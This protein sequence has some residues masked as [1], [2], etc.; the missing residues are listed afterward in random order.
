MN[1]PG[2]PAFDPRRFDPREGWRLARTC[3]G[4]RRWHAIERDGEA[5]WLLE[6]DWGQAHI[7][8]LV[9][10][11][12]PFSFAI[13]IDHSQASRGGFSVVLCEGLRVGRCMTHGSGDNGLPFFAQ[14]WLTLGIPADDGL[15]LGGPAVEHPRKWPA[16]AGTFA[17]PT[18]VVLN[19]S[20]SRCDLRIGEA[21]LGSTT[22]RTLPSAP[23]VVLVG[24]GSP[25]DPPAIAFGEIRIGPATSEGP[26][27]E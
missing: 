24:G 14:A 7:V 4:Y 21:A 10:P 16:P 9:V 26:A 5:F 27:V 19:C 13:R 1:S 8:G 2:L 18:S 6:S 11:P 22:L 25:D 3:G 12:G 15:T 23:L 20:P 17:R